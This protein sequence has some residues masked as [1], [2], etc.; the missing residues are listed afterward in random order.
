LKEVFSDS[1]GVITAII[2][3]AVVTHAAAALGGVSALP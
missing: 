2:L 3:T 1:L